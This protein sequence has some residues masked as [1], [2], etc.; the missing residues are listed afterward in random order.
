MATRSQFEHED[1]A[2]VP[3]GFK[4]RT[5]THP[6]GHRVRV[7]FPSGR[8]STGS[9]TLISILHPKGENPARCPGR[10]TLSN[11]AWYKVRLASGHTFLT[12]AVNLKDAWSQAKEEAKQDS[13]SVKKIEL[14][15]PRGKTKTR[16]QVEAMQ[17][18]AAN[19]LRNVVGDDDK[20]DEI[21]AL[22]VA[23]YAERK[24]ITLE[25][26]PIT[27]AQKKRLTHLS[28]GY[29]KRCGEGC[30]QSSQHKEPPPA[31]ALGQS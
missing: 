11:P 2:A 8:R 28:V 19:F 26:P 14:S 31:K 16:E 10:Q 3:R 18:K 17:D 5:V 27:P 12:Q 21:D 30:R 23:E 13:T 1:V 24:K 6:S 4:V 29:C 15:N 20:A 22:S 25:N 7:A 9:G